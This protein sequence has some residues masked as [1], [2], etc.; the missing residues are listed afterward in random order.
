MTKKL[1]YEIDI[2]EKIIS[3]IRVYMGDLPEFN[4]LIEGTE[5]SDEKITLAVQ[6]WINSFNNIPP[7]INKKFGANDFPNYL[8]MFQGCL[9]EIMKMAGILQSRNTLR[10]N[11]GGAQFTVMDKGQ[12]Y[13]QWINTFMSTHTQDVKDL[14]LALNAENAYNHY[15]SPEGFWPEL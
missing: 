15:E 11:D 10:F 7:I 12:E 3:D 4:R 1:P 8:I 9:M 14:K 13:M 5:I 2:P 6:L